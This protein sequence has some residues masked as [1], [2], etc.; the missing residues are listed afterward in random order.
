MR[1]PP[2]SATHVGDA[3]AFLPIYAE[4][5]DAC[6]RCHQQ[7]PTARTVDLGDLLTPPP[8]TP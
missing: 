1:R 8:P 4:L 5:A 6:R 3:Q 2:R 7:S